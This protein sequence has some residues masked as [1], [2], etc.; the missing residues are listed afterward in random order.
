V[1]VP[2]G[3]SEGVIA[4]DSFTLTATSEAD[5]GVSAAAVGVTHAVVEVGVS[6]TVEPEAGSAAPGGVAVYDL[7]ITNTGAYTDT[8]ALSADGNWA[9]ALSANS[10]GALGPGES[11]VVELEV[12]VPVQAAPGDADVTTVQATSELDVNVAEVAQV[13]TSVAQH[14]LFMPMVINN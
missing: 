9:S 8:F 2:E 1:Q 10:T 7:Q 5:P 13:W 11:I 6:V 14:K 3:V 12:S 4:S